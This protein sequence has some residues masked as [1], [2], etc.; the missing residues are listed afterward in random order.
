MRREAIQRLS[1]K[2]QDGG[3]VLFSFYYETKSA[4]FCLFVFILVLDNYTS[5]SQLLN[6]YVISNAEKRNEIWFMFTWA[7]LQVSVARYVSET[8]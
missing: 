6:L 7:V 2:V 3:K 4:C 1:V 5:Y 8:I